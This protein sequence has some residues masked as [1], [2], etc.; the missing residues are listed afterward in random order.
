MLK[1]ISVRVQS[2]GRITLPRPVC[3]RLG[4]KKGSRVTFIET[5]EGIVIRPA[6]VVADEALDEIGQALKAKGVKLKDGLKRG[7]EN[8]SDFVREGYGPRQKSAGAD[9]PPVPR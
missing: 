1:P 7:R 2:K 4:L 6:A 8:R 9:V 5:S 3:E